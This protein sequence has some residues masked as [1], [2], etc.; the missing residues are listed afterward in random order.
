MNAINHYIQRRLTFLGYPDA[1]V[2]IDRPS[3]NSCAVNV[4]FGCQLVSSCS[5]LCERFL[6]SLP[7]Q[8]TSMSSL[9]RKKRNVTAIG[10]IWSLIVQFSDFQVVVAESS[11]TSEPMSMSVRHTLK[12]YE[13][14]RSDINLSLQLSS[15]RLDIDKE[16]LRLKAAH[17]LL[18]N[19]LVWIADDAA[20]TQS[21]LQREVSKLL[22]PEIP[23][24]GDK[25]LWDFD[26]AGGVSVTVS[27]KPYLINE[28]EADVARYHQLP[29]EAQARGEGVLYW[30]EVEVWYDNGSL[31]PTTR[32]IEFVNSVIGLSSLT[33]RDCP[34]IPALVY[35]AINQARPHF[36]C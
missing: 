26:T 16:W 34:G 13:D 29:L 31:G 9:L 19:F 23:D 2:T 22:S 27:A 24:A 5:T 3:G 21:I 36:Q 8:T 32:S 4:G 6:S 17:R 7:E 15:V 10:D 12:A 1:H 14:Y 11:P 25:V 30:L 20:A 33:R 35:K 18:E 28:A